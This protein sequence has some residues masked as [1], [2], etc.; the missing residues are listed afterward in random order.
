MFRDLWATHRLAVLL[1]ATSALLLI[2]AVVTLP[3]RD[4]TRAGDAT[5]PSAPTGSLQQTRTIGD[6]TAFVTDGAE[7]D[8]TSASAATPTTPVEYDHSAWDAVPP[9]SPRTSSAYPPI[10]ANLRTQ[11]D[12][13]ASAFGTEL[14]TRNY[15]T[16]SRADLLSW[17]QSEAAALTIRQVAL[18]ATDREKALIMSL[19]SPDWDGSPTVIVPSASDWADLAALRAYTTVSDVKV[20][21]VSDFPPADVSFSDQLTLARLYS[22]SV[23]QHSTVGGSVVTVSHS[24]AFQIVL[25]TSLLHG[26]V[27]GAA[28][29]Q[30]FV[31]RGQS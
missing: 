29:T 3:L 28:C 21:A 27:F 24:V 4:G 17:A 13:F 9:V 10:A 31:E 12:T 5:S 8:V 18:T 22:A 15:A 11:P 1:A 23:T 16:S 7:A 26:T 2:V 19:T 20:E 30:N 25:G 14:L 6:T